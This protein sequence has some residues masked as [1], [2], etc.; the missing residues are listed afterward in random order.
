MY[1]NGTVAPL[2]IL[3]N[4]GGGSPRVGAHNSYT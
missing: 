1:P 4:E 3:I 2:I